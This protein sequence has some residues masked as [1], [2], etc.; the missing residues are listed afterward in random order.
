MGR[1]HLKTAI[2]EG[3]TYFSIL[4]DRSY[5]KNKHLSNVTCFELNGGSEC[6]TVLS[7]ERG[8]RPKMTIR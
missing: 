5:N 6:F 4:K 1:R 7:E 2:V 8:S 3:E